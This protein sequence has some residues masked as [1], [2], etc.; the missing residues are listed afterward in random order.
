MFSVVTNGST[1]SVSDVLGKSDNIE[2]WM[3][4]VST[5]FLTTNIGGQ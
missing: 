4:L 3:D 1:V 2:R 5:G